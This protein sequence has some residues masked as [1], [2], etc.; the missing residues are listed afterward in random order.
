MYRMGCLSDKGC[1]WVWVCGMGK[2]GVRCSCVWS[3]ANVGLGSGG[4][5]LGSGGIDVGLVVNV[6]QGRV[7]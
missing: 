7:G 2:N 4:C 1:V 3:G 5:G 6:V